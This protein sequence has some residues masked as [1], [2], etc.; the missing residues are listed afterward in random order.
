MDP[1][2]EVR[3]VAG[4][5][6]HSDLALL[7]RQATAI[8]SPSPELRQPV[9]KRGRVAGPSGLGAML[10]RQNVPRAEGGTSGAAVAPA[11]VRSAKWSFV[12]SQRMQSFRCRRVPATSRT[13]PVLAILWTAASG[14]FLETTLDEGRSP[15]AAAKMVDTIASNSTRN[16]VNL[17]IVGL[18]REDGGLRYPTRRLVESLATNAATTR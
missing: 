9:K 8:Q 7:H 17:R 18:A 6:S 4:Q 13:T 10:L 11:T 16:L 14:I 5:G 12:R 3:R 2:V 15:G 1:A